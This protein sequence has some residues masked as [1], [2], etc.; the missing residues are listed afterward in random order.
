MQIVCFSMDRVFQLSEYLRTLHA[1]VTFQHQP[2][3]TWARVGIICRCSTP[4]I[5]GFYE[6]LQ[7]QHPHAQFLYESESLDF[8]GAVLQLLC[9][10]VN[11][12][13]SA[14]DY[15]MLN[16]DDAFY[17][18][19]V[20]LADTA[21][22]FLD[23]TKQDRDW[24]FA[25]HV[26]L[27][28]S[29][30][31]SHLTNKPMLPLP[32]MI[33]VVAQPN[34]SS[35]L[36]TAIRYHRF[37]PSDGSLDWNYP[38]DLSGSVY[39]CSTVQ[40][41]LEGIQEQFGRDGLKNPNQ[42]ELR[43]HQV[44][45]QWMRKGERALCCGCMPAPV[46]H[47]FAINQVQDVFANRLY[48]SSSDA[49]SGELTDLLEFYKEK[50]SLDESYYR[51][52]RLS[53]V[54]IGT[55]VL[56]AEEVR[57]Q[58]H[59][60]EQGQPSP[61]LVS[62]VM[63][64]HNA[65]LYIDEAL[66]SLFSQT[67]TNLEII[68]IDDA[69]SDNTP[70]IIANWTK[71]DPRILSFRNDK[72]LGVAE[73]LNRG[74]ACASGEL[75]ARMDGDDVS[76]QDRIRRQVDFLFANPQVSIVG[77]SILISHESKRASETTIYPTSALLVKWQM[78]FGC[79][80]AHPTVMMR[81]KTLELLTQHDE[82]LYS[83]TTGSSED[84]ELWLRCI[85]RHELELRNIGDVLLVHRK[86]GN[87]ESTRNRDQQASDA[88]SIRALCIQSIGIPEENLMTAVLNVR[89]VGQSDRSAN[90]DDLKKSIELLYQLHDAITATRS[91][92]NVERESEDLESELEYVS[93]DLAA[94]EGEL[95]LRA[96]MQDP[97]QGSI[98]WRNFATRHPQVSR[99][100]FQRLL[101]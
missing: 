15:V 46:M 24:P 65:G 38:W 52:Q 33:S 98:L 72:N 36:P 11:E 9:N 82:P 70:G 25:F 29:I 58:D 2:L 91:K 69:S 10:E 28:P 73:S 43:G 30:W 101:S 34:E 42:F 57:R 3:A 18:D 60:E 44:V 40:K 67:Y 96:M 48:Q 79:F 14:C 84:Y 19:Q 21:F 12:Q 63:P 87:N 37:S 99:Q 83:T 47:V 1:F 27:A 39:S 23:Q 56:K 78:L 77:T 55:L 95:A 5:R 16:V 66:H 94:R 6:E 59:D 68:V 76:F 61:V 4:E 89:M 8:A 80:L 86:H 62:I 22:A 88:H 41:V 13:E 64:V 85:F 92:K 75:I 74:F 49:P 100:A 32:K 7:A 54:H 35:R 26:K 71:K 50:K 97:F 53:S 51:R 81:R 17:F 90:T 45:Q 31:R 93:N 20:D